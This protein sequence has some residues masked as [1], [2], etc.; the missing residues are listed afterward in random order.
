V[1]PLH[2]TAKTAFLA[3]AEVIVLYD[4]ITSDKSEILAR[5][6]AKVTARQW[7]AVSTDELEHGLPCS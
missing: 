6:R 5:A 2:Y 1:S 7:P 3:S 4:F